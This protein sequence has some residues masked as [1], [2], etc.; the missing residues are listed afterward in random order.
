ML[1]E[2]LLKCYAWGK[3]YTSLMCIV[4]YVL[5]YSQDAEACNSVQC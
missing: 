5:M 2:T 1:N 3:T 4:H